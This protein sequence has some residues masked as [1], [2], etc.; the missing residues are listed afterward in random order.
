MYKTEG[1]SRVRNSEQNINVDA[2]CVMHGS[3]G[4]IM[5]GRLRLR[6]IHDYIVVDFKCVGIDT[7]IIHT[8]FA[9]GMGI[10]CDIKGHE[11]IELR[12]SK[13]TPYRSIE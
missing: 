4:L 5:Q 10:N 11:W 8:R 1:R 13:K 3:K 9:R 6:L 7:C 12:A 2:A